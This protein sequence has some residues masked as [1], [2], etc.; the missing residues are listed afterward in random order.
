MTN[1]M[2]KGVLENME[3]ARNDYSGDFTNTVALIAHPKAV[4][5]VRLMGVQTRVVNQPERNG[6]LLIARQMQGVGDLFHK[7][8]IELAKKSA[9]TPST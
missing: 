1:N 4:G 5:I 9:T 2:P 6:A 8:S 3:G 7:Y